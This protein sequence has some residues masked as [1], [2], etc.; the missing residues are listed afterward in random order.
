MN[1]TKQLHT[2]NTTIAEGLSDKYAPVS[3]KIVL[4]PFYNNGWT[5]K[6]RVNSF[7]R[8]GIGKEHLTL[9]HPDFLYPNGDQLTIECLNSNN[10]L[11]ALMLMG[12]YGRV[13]C[14]NG[15]IIGDVEG[16]RFVHRGTSIYE[17][18][19]DQYDTIIG[20]L[21]KIKKS[22]EV[23]K[24]STLTEDQLDVVIGNIAKRVFE[25]DTK[26]FN[27]VADIAVSSLRTI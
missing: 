20:H 8:N 14:S 26:K 21:D 23:L 7:N 5:T 9:T 4:A 18:I 24:E 17:K 22:V 6:S 12:G 25:R 19:E 1:L 10:G 27:T 11:G 15:L 2:N 3:T 16:G 13:V